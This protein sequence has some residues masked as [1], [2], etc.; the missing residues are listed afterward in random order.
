MVKAYTTRVG[1]GPFP[2]EL[3]NDIGQHI[4]DVGREYGTVTG[5]P[6]RCGWFDAVAAGYGAGSAASIALAVMLLDVLS[7]LD[8]INVCTAYEIDGER[9]TDFPSHVED[10][11]RAKPVY[12][13]AARLEERHLECPP[14]GR[15]PQTGAGLSRHAVGADGQTGRN[16]LRRPR[17]RA[18]DFLR[19]KPVEEK[20]HKIRVAKNSR[21]TEAASDFPMDYFLPQILAFKPFGEERHHAHGWRAVPRIML[22]SRTWYQNA[23][24]LSVGP[25]CHP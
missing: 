13:S 23:I 17:P 10:L 2:T 3:N 1:G 5:R 19:L 8:E 22:P 6:R 4:R 12:R 9:T 11:A 16:R 20:W 15:F 25:L 24:F 21:L 7:Q 14:H 18:D